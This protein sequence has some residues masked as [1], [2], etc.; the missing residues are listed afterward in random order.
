[1]C[2]AQSN[3]AALRRICVPKWCFSNLIAQR[4]W[5]R[6]TDPSTH[7]D[8]LQ[9]VRL[10]FKIRNKRVALWLFPT[11]RLNFIIITAIIYIGARRTEGMCWVYC[12]YINKY[13]FTRDRNEIWHSY[14]NANEG[15]NECCFGFTELHYNEKRRTNVS[16]NSTRSYRLRKLVFRALHSTQMKLSVSMNPFP[17]KKQNEGVFPL[18]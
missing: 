12:K 15:E 18:F 5:S 7:C 14:F 6:F 13:K 2:P 10:I 4:C 1:M 9:H 11:P 3:F 16:L 17:R 8:I